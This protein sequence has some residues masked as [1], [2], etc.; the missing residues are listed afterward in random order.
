MGI[1]GDLPE[2][3]KAAVKEFFLNYQNADYFQYM[4]GMA[5]E[6]EPRYVEALDSDYDYVRDLMAKVIPE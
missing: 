1:R 6:D 4:V 2:D 5:P 3:L